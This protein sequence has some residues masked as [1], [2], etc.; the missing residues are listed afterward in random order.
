[1]GDLLLI[2][3]SGLAREALEVERAVAQHRMIYV[4]D[5]DERLWDSDLDGASIV[6]GLQEVKR[7]GDAEILVCAGHGEVRRAIVER[8]TWLGVGADRYT[9]VVHPSVDVPD[10]CTVG[11]GTILMAQVALTA[12][13]TIGRH[14]VIMPNVTLTHDNV[15]QDYVTVAAGAALGGTVRVGTGAYLGMNASVRERV[16]VGAGATLG[17]GAALV[18]DLPAGQTWAGVPARQIASQNRAVRK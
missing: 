6:G 1:M 15:L 14:V 10:N 7:Y 3:A 12:D 16:A 2:C 8:L 4:L 11:V 9:R 18:Q 5:D 17:M 13:V